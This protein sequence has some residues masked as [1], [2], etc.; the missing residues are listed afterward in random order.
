[1]TEN[2][3]KRIYAIVFG[4][5]LAGITL[6]GLEVLASLEAPRWPAR[7]LRSTPPATVQL[8]DF[9]DLADKPWVFEPNNSWGM[10]D[11]ERSIAKPESPRP[12]MRM[13]WSCNRF[14]F[15]VASKWTIRPDTATW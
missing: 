8:S 7:A 9:T 12:R 5:I 10:R 3:R 13:C 11:K 14:M 6:A 2:G 15:N 4:L 1:M